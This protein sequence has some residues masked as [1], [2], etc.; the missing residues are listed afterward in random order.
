MKEGSVSDLGARGAC[1][2]DIGRLQ[3][4]WVMLFVRFPKLGERGLI[5]DKIDR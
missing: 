2:G 1:R 3:V 5:I 4:L